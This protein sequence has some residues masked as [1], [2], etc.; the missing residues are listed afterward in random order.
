MAIFWG[1]ILEMLNKT[2]KTL[3]S[4]S[5]DLIT[6]VQLYDSVIHYIKSARSRSTFLN[7]NMSAK[8]LSGLS[9]YEEN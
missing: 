3:Q 6:V 9:I 4:V 5:K 1:D 8:K 2:N 7:Y